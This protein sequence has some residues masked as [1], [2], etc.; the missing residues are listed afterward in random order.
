MMTFVHLIYLNN[1]RCDQNP[2]PTTAPRAQRN[3]PMTAEDGIDAEDTTCL[4]PRTAPTMEI[5]LLTTDFENQIMDINDND[6]DM[7]KKIINLFY[8]HIS[9]FYSPPR[10]TTL[11]AEMGLD[12]GTSYDLLV[13]DENRRSMG[14][15]QPRTE[16]ESA[17]ENE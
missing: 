9:E 7:N 8:K 11:A 14:L 13:H 2:A 4:Y 6:P 3:G 17:A 10:V 5:D 12:P 16:R 1:L 15:W